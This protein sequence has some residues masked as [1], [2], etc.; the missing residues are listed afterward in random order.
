MTHRLL[1]GHLCVAVA[2]HEAGQVPSKQAAVL[3]D[4][5]IV[6]RLLLCVLCVCVFLCGVLE[7]CGV[8]LDY[9]QYLLVYDNNCKHVQPL[10]RM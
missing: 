3:G 6:L 9:A 5:C 4:G 8:L 7:L 1:V 10:R 2:V